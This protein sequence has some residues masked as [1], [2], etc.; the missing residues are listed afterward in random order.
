VGADDLR[1]SHPGFGSPEAL[2]QAIADNQHEV[3]GLLNAGEAGDSVSVG[4]VDSVYEPPEQLE[5]K[6]SIVRN[7]ELFQHDRGDTT[8]HGNQVLNILANLSP[9]SEFYL[10]R[11]VQPNARLRERHLINAIGW[12]HTE[13]EVDVINISLG[14][15]HSEDGNGECGRWRTPCRV[16]HAAEQAI[17][18]GITV[19]A[20]AGNADQYDSVCCPSLFDRAIS[21]GGFISE[22]TCNPDIGNTPGGITFPPKSGWIPGGQQDTIYCTGQDC[23]PLPEHSCDAARRVRNWSGN[24][25]PVR[26]KPDILAPAELVVMGSEG[27]R[28]SLATSWATP[29]VAAMIA[30]TIGYVRAQGQVVRPETL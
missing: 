12:A 21:V 1:F 16:N 10:Y 22:C 11:V 30:E 3:A 24:V 27:T 26:N 4:V 9:N 19:V 7:R 28:I 20:A 25:N 2:G 13:D 6:V 18:D 5:Q 23:S 29:R 17:D 14:N 8:G 15:D